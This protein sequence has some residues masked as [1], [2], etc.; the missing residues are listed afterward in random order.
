VDVSK[1]E[2]IDEIVSK[3]TGNVWDH[4]PI[5]TPSILIYGREKVDPDLYTGKL[6]AYPLNSYI[7]NYCNN[8]GYKINST[9]VSQPPSG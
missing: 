7:K 4:A 9:I 3:Y 8:F 2:N 6:L 1:P 5:S